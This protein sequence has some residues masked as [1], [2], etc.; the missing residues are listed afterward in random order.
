L[1]K[2]R[3]KFKKERSKC[4]T[5]RNSITNLKFAKKK[6]N[7]EILISCLEPSELNLI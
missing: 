7:S 6:V 2:E 4:K 3:K 1:I 5:K